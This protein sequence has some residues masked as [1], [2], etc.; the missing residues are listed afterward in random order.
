MSR[1]ECLLKINGSSYSIQEKINM[2]TF[3][4]RY[5]NSL[6]T[7][8]SVIN[9]NILLKY[10]KF[11]NSLTGKSDNIDYMNFL[12]FHMNGSNHMDTTLLASC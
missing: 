10:P 6:Q 12:A 3:I 1:M 5:F 7:N 9:N 2:K 8:K 11:A 4:N